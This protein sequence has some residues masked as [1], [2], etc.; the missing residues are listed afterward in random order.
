MA[1]IIHQDHSAD[2]MP[3][4]GVISDYDI[5][6]Q[7]RIT[8]V[9]R[10]R[11]SGSDRGSAIRDLDWSAVFASVVIGLGLTVMLTVLG[12]ATGLIA[13]DRHSSAGDIGGIVGSIGAWAVIAAIL[14]TFIGSFAGGRFS[15]GLNRGSIGYHAATAWGV[16]TLLTLVLVTF[17]TM[18]FVSSASTVA[19]T[20]AATNK[21]TTTP[22]ATTPAATTAPV[23]NT[24]TTAA[25]D[26]A[27]STADAL[28]GAG[29]ALTIGMLLTLVAS[30][31]GWYV[32]S[33][34]PLTSLER[35]DDATPMTA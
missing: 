17:L 29:V 5:N 11:F 30:V 27:A 6:R 26:T 2:T 4:A 31:A 1:R 19:A 34:K 10:E 16:A 12:V 23:P 35:E 21:A 15:R 22:A 3:G 18:G 14:A 9:P 13:S 7:S 25:K 33:R 20:A 24:S 28:G 32:G 8:G